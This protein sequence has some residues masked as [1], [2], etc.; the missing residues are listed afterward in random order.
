MNPTF[1]I[2]EKDYMRN[3]QDN[4]AIRN[5]TIEVTLEKSE[6]AFISLGFEYALIAA[7]PERYEY[8]MSLIDRERNDRKLVGKDESIVEV[9]LENRKITVHSSNERVVVEWE[10]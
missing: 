8:L 9:E 1:L 5:E 4:I 7:F 10:R 6:Y 3:F 2:Y